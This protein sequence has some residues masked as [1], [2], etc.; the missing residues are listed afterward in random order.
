MACT[1]KALIRFATNIIIYCDNKTAIEILLGKTPKKSKKEVYKIWKIQSEWE[2]R[3]RL[4]HVAAGGIF[5]IWIQGHS[6]NVGNEE[7]DSLARAGA[8]NT[9]QIQITDNPL[10]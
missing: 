9:N 6:G 8:Q 10:T 4:V 5:C 7:A 1:T 3:E 2:K